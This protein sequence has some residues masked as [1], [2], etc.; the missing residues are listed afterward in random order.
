MDKIVK[1]VNALELQDDDSTVIVEQNN[2][3]SNMTSLGIEVFKLFKRHL[4]RKP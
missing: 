3:A 4:V 1:R 2:D